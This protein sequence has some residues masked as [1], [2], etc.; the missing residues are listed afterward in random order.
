M[1]NSPRHTASLANSSA[2]VPC[3]VSAFAIA[4]VCC[5]MSQSSMRSHTRPHDN[6]SSLV[7]G[8]PVRMVRIA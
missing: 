5:S 3:S 7:I 8:L 4:I 6:A 2:T 1:L